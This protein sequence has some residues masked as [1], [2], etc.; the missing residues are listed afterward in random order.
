MAQRFELRLAAVVFAFGA[1]GALA[2]GL[3]ARAEASSELARTARFVRANQTALAGALGDAKAE[4]LYQ[5]LARTAPNDPETWLRLGNLYAR[6]NRP[7]E[8]ADYYRAALA[9]AP[10]MAEL[11]GNLA[12]AQRSVRQ[13]FD[14]ITAAQ[15]DNNYHLGGYAGRAKELLREANEQIKFAAQTANRR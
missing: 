12:A 3:A 14:S 9:Q 1:A 15:Q 13:A 8:A 2:G 4:A 7:D 5:G 6:S 10:N 11:H